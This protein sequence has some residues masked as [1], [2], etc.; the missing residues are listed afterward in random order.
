MDPVSLDTPIRVVCARHGQP[1]TPA[2]DGLLDLRCDRCRSEPDTPMQRRRR[3]VRNALIDGLEWAIILPLLVG[4][5]A[6]VGALKVLEL[7]GVR[8]LER[9]PA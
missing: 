8:V 3:T 6:Y 2:P 5:F 1:I 4:I 7:V 9:D